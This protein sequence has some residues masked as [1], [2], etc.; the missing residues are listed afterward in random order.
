MGGCEMCREV[1]VFIRSRQ[2]T[3][4]TKYLDI[5]I[6]LHTAQSGPYPEPVLDDSL[7]PWMS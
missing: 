4:S 6:V 2:L 3:H 7:K 5:K 1:C